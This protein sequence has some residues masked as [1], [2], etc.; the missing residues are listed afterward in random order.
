MFSPHQFNY[1]LPEGGPSPRKKYTQIGINFL[2]KNVTATY[3]AKCL[4]VSYSNLFHFKFQHSYYPAARAAPARLL[5]Q[6]PE[7]KHDRGKNN[8]FLFIKYFFA[9]PQI[10]AFTSLFKTQTLW[11]QN[12]ARHFFITRN[13]IKFYF[14]KLI[15]FLH[16]LKYPSN[17]S[18][19]C[20]I[21]LG[22]N[23]R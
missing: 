4:T 8:H 19:E 20:R 14:N 16:I 12:L 17:V 9:K 6:H 7:Q 15:H 5:S 18:V 10:A 22:K 11:F 13:F 3:V 1:V 23:L 21:P 2:K